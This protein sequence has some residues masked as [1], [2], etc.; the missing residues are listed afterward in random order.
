MGTR[1]WFRAQYLTGEPPPP[2]HL[3]APAQFLNVLYPWWWGCK[4][5]VF[6]CTNT[7]CC[8]LSLALLSEVEVT[9]EA[10][11][12]VKLPEFLCDWCETEQEGRRLLWRFPR[13]PLSFC[14]L[15][16]PQKMSV[17]LWQVFAGELKLWCVWYTL[18]SASDC[19]SCSRWMVNLCC[20]TLTC[21]KVQVCWEEVCL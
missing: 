14:S 19:S 6:M 18:F 7:F 10:W 11:N 8:W 21:V 20:F 1:L 5:I 2:D 13:V 16:F 3:R 9:L 12:E 15:V 4:K 17:Y